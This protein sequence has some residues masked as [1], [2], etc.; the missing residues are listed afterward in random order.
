[1]VI[2]CR[3]GKQENGGHSTWQGSVSAP[4]YN[5]DKE[6]EQARQFAKQIP[7]EER[8]SLHG[9]GCLKPD[10]YAVCPVVHD[11]YRPN[12]KKTALARL[13]VVS[14]SLK[15]AKFG[16]KKKNRQASA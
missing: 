16:V 15:V 14:R 9:Q 6:A 4:C 12:L 2:I 3:V 11:Y 1:M 10:P 13:S 7:R 8:V 5:K